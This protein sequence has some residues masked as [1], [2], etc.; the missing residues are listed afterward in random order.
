MQPIKF[1]PIL[2]ETIWG[3]DKIPNIK[4]IS[5]LEDKHIG[6]S[7][8]VSGL[9]GSESVVDGGGRYAIVTSYRQSERKTYR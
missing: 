7:W 1:R 6:E 9:E 5:G 4:N 8:E 2:K 3:G